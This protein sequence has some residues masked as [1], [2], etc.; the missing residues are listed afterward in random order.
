MSYFED[1]SLVLIPSAQKLSKIYSVKP[2]DG[3]GD[4]TFTRSNDTATRVGPDGLI[5]KVRTNLITYSEQLDNAAWTKADTTIVANAVANPLNGAVT[6]DKMTDAST[7]TTARYTFQSA[8][9]SGTIYTSSGYFKKAE[10]NFVTLHAYGLGG[11]VFNLDTGVKVSQSGGVGTITSVG[12]GW[13]RCTFSFTAG[14]DTVFFTQSPAGS[15]SYAGTTG[16]G[17][18]AFG[19]QLETGDIATPYIGPTLAAAVSVGPV[20]NVPR[21]DYLGSSCPRLILEGQ[22]TNSQTFSEQH[23]NAVWTKFNLT[24]SQN[25]GTSPDGYTNADLVYPDTG[26]VNVQNYNSQTRGGLTSGASYTQSVFLKAS[27]FTWAIVDNVSGSAGAWFNLVTGSI[28]TVVAGSTAKI[29]N[30]GNGWYRCSVTS[31]AFSTTGYGDYRLA[32][33]DNVALATANGTDGILAWGFQ[34]EQGYATSYIPTLGA[35]VTRGAESAVKTGISSLIG[36]T[37]GVLY[38]EFSYNGSSTSGAY[39]RII[40]VGDGNTNDRIILIKN[41]TS[42]E[43]YAFIGD[44]GSSIVNQVISGTNILGTHKVAFAYKTN[45]FAVY[46]DGTLVYSSAS[47]TVPTT[48]NLYVGV[49]EITGTD[50]QLGGTISQAL[51]FKTRL[52]N[53]SLAEL[54]SL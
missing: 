49:N 38:A 42:S 33:A 34:F 18:F 51:V 46:L 43:L 15:I 16:S 54:T 26:V 4:L 20:A 14:A 27:G 29:E 24:V 48:S 31:S 2:T 36:Q 30:Y 11:A 10:Y 37:E 3:T 1:A 13:Y 21:L 23:N 25:A 50:I 32:N 28:G 12:D 5:E 41:N 39:E 52:S 17:I 19:L 44:N 6:A 53:S 9:S 35:A 40:G 45:D 22:R 47:G 7:A 8:A